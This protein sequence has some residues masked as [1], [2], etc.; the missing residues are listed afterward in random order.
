MYEP[1]LWFVLPKG[2]VGID[3]TR[4]DLPYEDY[5]AHFD[6][7]LRKYIPSPGEW[8]PVDDALFS[9]PDLYTVAPDE[10]TKLQLAALQYSFAH[11]YEHN[12][13]YRSYCQ[14]YGMAP[15]DIRTEHD[16]ARIPLISDAFFKNHPEGREFATWLGSIFTG[17]LP[18][19]VIEQQHPNCDQVVNAFNAAGMVVSYS[20][21]TGGRHTFIPRDRRTFNNAEYALAKC[22]LAMSCGR[23]IDRSETYLLMPDPR[24][25]TIYAGKSTE[26]M[27]DLLGDMKVGIK[28]SLS[29]NLIGMVMGNRG[30]FKGTLVRLAGRRRSRRMIDDVIKWLEER[31]ESPDFTFLCGAPYLLHAVL[32][33]LTR[34]NKR[35]E[36]GERGGV[37]TG[38]G[39]KIRENQRLPLTEFRQAVFDVLGIPGRY[40][41]D[42][43]GMVESNGWMVQCP[44]G[45]YLHVPYTYFKPLVFDTE[46]K[47]LPY[48][49]WG[50]FGF[51][52]AAALSYPGFIL[53]GD[54]ARILE[55]C[56]TCDR[57]G[58]VLDPEVKRAASQED[59]GCAVEVRRLFSSD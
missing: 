37:V 30:G 50:R 41:L 29:L 31:Q 6:E 16:L 24:I 34:R 32:T 52:D 55:R 59:R 5:I 21:G 7:R 9:P 11:H 27:F 56:P 49:E 10:A 20:S 23:W 4:G 45:H 40:C 43:Y 25:N 54:T 28:Q 15:A 8:T 51:L 42:I 13:L 33:E 35:F 1:A 2:G 18:T 17:K 58:P 38:G 22:I 26:I 46:Q 53:T 39:W 12:D 48:G 36:F 47:P 57:P 44:E 19:V 14:Q 3:Y